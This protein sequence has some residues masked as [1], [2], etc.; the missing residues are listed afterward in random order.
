[1]RNDLKY[2]SNNLRFDEN[3]VKRQCL[4][5]IKFDANS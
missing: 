3:Y 4:L 1:M 5:Y 2:S